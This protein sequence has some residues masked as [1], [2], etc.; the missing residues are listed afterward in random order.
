M[1][2]PGNVVLLPFF[3]A[4]LVMGNTA[5]GAWGSADSTFSTDKSVQGEEM[6]LYG[7]G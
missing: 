2:I 1:M 7:D 3:V 6:D 5:R 4:L